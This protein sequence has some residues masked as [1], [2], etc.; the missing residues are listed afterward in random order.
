MDV[1]DVMDEWLTIKNMQTHYN[2]SDDWMYRFAAAAEFQKHVRKQH[3]ARNSPM[4]LR[5][6]AVAAAIDAGWGMENN[7]RR[8]AQ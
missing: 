7:G 5:R 3:T 2:M 4:V 1:M 6:S 8:V